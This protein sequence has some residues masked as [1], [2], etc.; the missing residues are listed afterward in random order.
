MAG[1][2]KID[3]SL[4]RQASINMQSTLDDLAAQ[5]KELDTIKTTLLGDATWKGPNKSS[6]VQKF[7]TYQSSLNEL[8][9][10]AQQ[11][12]EKLDE[13]MSNYSATEN[14]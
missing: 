4:A 6:F 7:E 10:N 8:Y 5:I 11:H 13:S 3:F 14:N 12:L 2:Y 1:G 9:Q